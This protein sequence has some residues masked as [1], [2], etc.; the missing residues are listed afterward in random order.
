ML[1]LRMNGVVSAAMRKS[2][3]E[4]KLNYGLDAR[5]IRDVASKIEHSVEM[6][7]ALW[8]ESSRECKIL[9]TLVHP[10]QEFTPEKA[11]EW[12]EGC[13]YS[14]LT[15]QLIFN[16]LQHLDSA[17]ANT[18]RWVLSENPAQ[19]EAGY[20]LA[21]RLLLK[22]QE[23]P[24]INALITAATS[25]LNADNYQLKLTVGRFLER[26]TYPSKDLQ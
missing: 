25:D 26:A 23:I 19:R 12:L 14:E 7:D 1:R 24:G 16:L 6:A 21:L 10:K 18:N 8:A 22:K 2:G 5:N 9:A 20:T 15:E 4:Y 17:S 13:F 11:D 3:L